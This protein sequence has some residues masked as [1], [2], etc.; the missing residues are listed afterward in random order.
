MKKTFTLTSLL[1]FLFS[2]NLCAQ[3]D[4][5]DVAELTLKVGAVKAEELF[6][7]FAEGDQIVFNFEEV[8]GKKL[9]ELEIIE[10]PSSSKFVDYQ[11]NKIE[12]KIIQVNNAGI[13]KF[14]FYNTA[15]SGRILKFK[16][17]RIPA[18]KETKNFNT[19]VHWKIVYD[20]SYTTVQEKYL[21][22]AD[23]IITHITD[24]VTKVHSITNIN[25]SKT[26]L[27]FTLPDNTIV[28]SYYIGVD[29]T[30]QQAFENATQELAK[31]TG[32]LVSKIPGYGPLAALALGGIS[33]LSQLQSG[34]NVQYW[35]VDGN[36]V[37][38]F[39]SEEQFYYFR[40]GNVINEYSKMD[41]PLKG[42]YYLCLYNDNAVQAID[43][44]VKITAIAVNEQ[45]G[46]RL[47]QKMNITSKREPY[48]KN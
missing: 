43:V 48:L 18:S 25:E 33:H 15:L 7:G 8:K 45:W 10:Y 5:V 22:K 34:E 24:Q 44:S 27:N 9:K 11:T 37:N 3:L 47:V 31:N 2:F 19:T 40:K 30:G 36:N 23:T 32:P 13:Y 21:I 38:L 42:T 39:E 46:T 29:Q 1:L 26:V 17:Q 16:I 20:T 4:P 6:Y 12:E 41:K 35:F 14:R 28:W